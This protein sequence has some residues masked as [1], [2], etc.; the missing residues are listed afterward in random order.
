MTWIITGLSIAGVVLNIY[1][2]REC[3]LIWTVTNGAWMVYDWSIG[4]KAQATLFAVY[5]VLA[6][7]GLL[8]WRSER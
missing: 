2:R 6:I 7:W 4:A 1:C 3:F 8:K 5:L